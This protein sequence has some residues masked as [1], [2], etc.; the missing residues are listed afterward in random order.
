MPDHVEASASERPLPRERVEDALAEI[1]ALL[2]RLR[3]VEGLL[4]EQQ[5]EARDRDSAPEHAESLVTRPI[6][7][8][9][10]KRCR[11][12]SGSTSGTSYARRA[13]VKSCSR[14]PSRCANR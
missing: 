14:C 4:K 3:L 13:T 11:G 6:S 1:T 8:I 9:C 10:L 2:R 12:T 7:P 5:A